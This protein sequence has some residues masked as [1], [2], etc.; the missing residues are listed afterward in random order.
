MSAPLLAVPPAIALSP[1]ATTDSGDSSANAVVT[2][3]HALARA[4][5]YLWTAGA[6]IGLHF[7]YVQ[8]LLAQFALFSFVF[9]SLSFVALSVFFV[10][11]VS[12]RAATWSGFA[13]RSATAFPASRFTGKIVKHRA[14]SDTTFKIDDLYR[15]TIL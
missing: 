14:L 1:H 4:S 5:N 2:P 15:W 8:E 11:Y 12:N 9:F 7:Y 13:S 6:A 3:T 10:W